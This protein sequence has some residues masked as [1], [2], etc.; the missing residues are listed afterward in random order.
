MQF[1]QTLGHKLCLHKGE[2]ELAIEL[3]GVTNTFNEY[4]VKIHNPD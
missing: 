3:S 1:V 2:L 4:S